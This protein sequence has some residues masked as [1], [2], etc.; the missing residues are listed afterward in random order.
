M[1]LD[2]R[3]KYRASSVEQVIVVGLTVLGL[4]ALVRP[5]IVDEILAALAAAR[6][7][8]VAVDYV[9][10]GAGELAQTVRP[11]ASLVAALRATCL[12]E[13]ELLVVVARYAVLGVAVDALRRGPFVL[14]LLLLQNWAG[15]FF[16]LF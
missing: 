6:A 12:R 3:A 14:L 11:D 16:I 9:G 1:R 13:V 7:G 8:R 4:H 2:S 5:Y 10:L 15:S